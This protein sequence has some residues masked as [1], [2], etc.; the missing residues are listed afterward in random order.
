VDLLPSEI[1]V[2]VIGGI[3]NGIQPNLLQCC[4]K[5]CPL[6]QESA[7]QHWNASVLVCVM[8]YSVCFIHFCWLL[9][10][11]WF[12]VLYFYICAFNLVTHAD[13][14][15]G[16]KHLAVSVCLWFCLCICL[17][18]KRMIPKYSN[19]IHGMTLWYPTSDMILRLKGH[20]V[21]ICKNIEGDRV[22]G[23]SYW[24]PSLNLMK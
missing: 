2:R 13:D 8:K 20:R 17:S 12:I 24:V 7:A 3:T 4:G 22:A 21:T 19:L 5:V 9:P 16:V 11:L 1:F 14:S 6:E 10:V 23:V 18:Q 15:C